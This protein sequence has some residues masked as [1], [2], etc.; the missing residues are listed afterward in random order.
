MVD[1][2]TGH[3]TVRPVEGTSL[4]RVLQNGSRFNKFVIFYAVSHELIK[5]NES[6]V[7]TLDTPGWDVMSGTDLI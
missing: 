5:E 6:D 2:W 1:I 7:K 4:N 3:M